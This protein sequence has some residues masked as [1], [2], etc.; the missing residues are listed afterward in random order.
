MCASWSCED[1]ILVDERCDTHKVAGVAIKRKFGRARLSLSNK[2]AKL[3]ELP[4]MTQL[5]EPSKR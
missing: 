1:C 2:K 4:E 5:T 3:T